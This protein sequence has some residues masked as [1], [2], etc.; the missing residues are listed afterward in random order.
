M[1]PK[2]GQGFL[3]FAH[4]TAD[5]DYVNMAYLL[6][7]SIK[8][9][10]KINNFC[11]VVTKGTV[12]TDA[13]RNTFDHVIEI[14]TTP[15]FYSECLAWQLTPYKETFKL[16]CD[17]IVPR[18]IDHW[19][20]AC[21]LSDVVL[22]TDVRNYKGEVSDVRVYRR[23]FDNNHL[24]DAYNGCMYFR[25]SSH[26]KK[27]FDVA[28]LVFENWQTFRNKLLVGS[29]YNSPDTDV[30]FGVAATLLDTPCYLPLD[31]PTFAHMKG[32][33]NGWHP[34]MDWRDAVQWHIDDEHNLFV[35]G[36]AQQYPFHYYQKNFC[37]PELIAHYEK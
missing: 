30:V 31:F 33:I 22:T 24:V 27:F 8:K 28:K 13:Q 23:Y 37:T 17:M 3:T 20:D 9:S 29:I 12:L 2:N 25:Y 35:G 14:P 1:Q 6:A 32:A 19:W 4:N 18:S 5:V 36:V 16:E 15:T 7:L 10:C 34:N 26:S 21:R 11:V